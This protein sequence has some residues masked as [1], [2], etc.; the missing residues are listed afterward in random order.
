MRLPSLHVYGTS[1]RQLRAAAPC[2]DLAATFAP[3][4]RVVVQHK[5][6][7]LVPASAKFVEQ[8]APFLRRAL[9]LL[10]LTLTFEP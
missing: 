3:E 5:Q 7:H 9:T 8:Y 2:A 6:G 1:D 10:T 4:T